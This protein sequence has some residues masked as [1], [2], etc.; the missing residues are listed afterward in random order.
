MNFSV[1]IFWN[2]KTQKI[3]YFMNFL[4]KCFFKFVEKAVFVPARNGV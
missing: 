2:A 1:F 3:P 4:I